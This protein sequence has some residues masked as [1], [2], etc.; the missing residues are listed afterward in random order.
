MNVKSRQRSFTSTNGHTVTVW[1]RQA[2][3]T[4]PICYVNPWT[5]EPAFTF[6]SGSALFH[7]KHDPIRERLDTGSSPIRGWI[8]Y[9][10]CRIVPL[11]S[12]S[13]RASE[14]ARD[15]DRVRS[16]LSS[17]GTAGRGAAPTLRA[18]LR[19]LDGG[20]ERTLSP[21][22]RRRLAGLARA[23]A[24]RGAASPPIVASSARRSAG[25][26]ARAE[27]RKLPAAERPG[28][29]LDPSKLP[30]RPPGRP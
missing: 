28:W 10:P 3:F 6:P 23:A 21:A 5:H 19:W 12:L 8:T 11:T 7:V 13:L 20:A 17:P 29:M 18:W 25:R 30:L 2:S 14:H 22:R 9:D 26:E 16:I 15:V 24:T 27:G 1:L 4:Y